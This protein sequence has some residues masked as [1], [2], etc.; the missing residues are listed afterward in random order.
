MAGV[1]AVLALAGRL[2]FLKAWTIPDDPALNASLEP[3]L[4][5]G[6]VVLLLTRGTRG[7]GDLVRCPDPEDGQRWVVGRIAGVAGDEVRVDPSGILSVNGKRFSTTEACVDSE[8]SVAHPVSGHLIKMQCR[9]VEMAGGWHYHG[10][11]PGMTAKEYVHKVGPGRVFL[12]SDDRTFHDDS[13]DFGTVPVEGC[14]EKPVLRLWGKAGF[15]DAN[16]RFTAVR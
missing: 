1:C 16:R 8:F 12:L 6:D 2:L 3:T 14:V 9:R 10:I 4:G 7:F 11:A 15:S 5:S 13:R